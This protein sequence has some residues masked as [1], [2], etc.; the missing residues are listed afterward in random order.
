MVAPEFVNA[1]EAI[2]ID[3]YKP[4]WNCLI[5]GFGIHTLVKGGKQARSD[6]DMLHPEGI[7]SSFPQGTPLW[8]SPNVSKFI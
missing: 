6:R 4:L 2:L 7:F 3:H 1:A 8:T 5:S